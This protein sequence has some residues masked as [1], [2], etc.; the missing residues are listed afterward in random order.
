M[1]CYSFRLVID[2]RYANLVLLESSLVVDLW[3]EVVLQDSK[4][5]DFVL[6]DEWLLLVKVE[7]SVS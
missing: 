3:S 6:D 4:G 2:E 1:K 7:P 5:V